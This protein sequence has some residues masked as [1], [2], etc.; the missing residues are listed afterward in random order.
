LWNLPFFS[1][2]LDNEEHPMPRFYIHF[3]NGNTI[4][5]DDSGI[6]LPGLKEAKAAAIESGRKVLANNVKFN[7][8]NPLTEITITDR[9]GVQVASILAKDILPEPLR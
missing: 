7:A 1:R 5:I 9:S 4:A 8:D 6:D 3:H 2:L